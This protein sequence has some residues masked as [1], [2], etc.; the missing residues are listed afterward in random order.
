MATAVDADELDQ[1]NHWYGTNLVGLP[2][3]L[4]A[5]T[6][7]NSHP[8]P[9]TIAG[10]CETHP[11]LFTLLESSQTLTE[12]QDMFVHYLSIAFGLRKPEPHELSS[13]GRSEQRRWRS[14]WRK[15]LQGWGM[16]SRL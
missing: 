8:L 2:T 11:G 16:D 10:T 6:A 4:L 1:P 9:L 5:S 13:M 3:Q 15:L 12:A 14:S 7:F